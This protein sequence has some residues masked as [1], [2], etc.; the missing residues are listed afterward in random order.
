[1]EKSTAVRALADLLPEIGF[2][3]D[4]IFGCN[5]DEPNEMSEQCLKKP[6]PKIDIRKMKVINLPIG[7][8]EDRVVGTLDIEHA[9][10]KG[11][12]K[13]EPGILADA[14][15]NILYVDE[16]N[17]A[18]VIK[19]SGIKSLVIDAEK[20]FIGLGFAQEISNELGARYMKLEELRAQD[21][22]DGIRDIGM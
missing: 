14:H 16:V 19:A 20:S 9:I 13:F 17:L 5:P 12:K 6:E 21:I 1:M 3:R 8:T 18:S 4:C 10:K 22:V 15:R 11:E 2:V 7:S